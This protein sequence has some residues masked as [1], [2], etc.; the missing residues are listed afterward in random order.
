MAT[1]K[2]TTKSNTV[3]VNVNNEPYTRVSTSSSKVQID[4]KTNKLNVSL[5]RVGPQ[6]AIPKVNFSDLQDVNVSS[7]STGDG[8]VLNAENQWVP[9]TFT[10]TSLADIDNTAKTNGSILIYSLADHKYKA[11]NIIQD[12][13]TIKGGTF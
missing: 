5:A 12:D 13:M 2:I 9:H 3:K 4:V 10:T 7:A 1:T 11:T 6:G 8:I